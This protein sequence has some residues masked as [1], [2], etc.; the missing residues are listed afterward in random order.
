M[1]TKV[2][3]DIWDHG[4]I[5]TTKC[6]GARNRNNKDKQTGCKQANRLASYFQPWSLKPS[7]E[8]HDVSKVSWDD[9]QDMKWGKTQDCLFFRTYI[10]YIW[11]FRTSKNHSEGEITLWFDHRRV[12]CGEGLKLT[13]VYIKESQAKKVGSHWSTLLYFQIKQKVDTPDILEVT[14]T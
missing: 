8:S 3:P 1:L 13:F 4:D 14:L 5:A 9:Y 2:I 6:D 12:C 11:P 10:L 7:K